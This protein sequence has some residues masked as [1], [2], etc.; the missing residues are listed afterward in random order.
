MMIFTKYLTAI[1][2]TFLVIFS[3][4]GH[5]DAGEKDNS[6]QTVKHYY[7][8]IKSENNLAKVHGDAGLS[9][10]DCHSDY[11]A[12]GNSKSDTSVLKL[13]SSGDEL[14]LKCHDLKEVDNKVVYKGQGPSGADV[15]PHSQHVADIHCATCH[16]MHRKSNLMCAKCHVQKWMKTLPKRWNTPL[17]TEN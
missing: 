13:K 5:V 12:K 16:S 6:S 11:T 9:C 1:L 7:D 14:C 17:K 4:S 3:L 8:S 2:S 10:I 15:R